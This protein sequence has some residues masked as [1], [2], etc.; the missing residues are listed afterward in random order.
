MGLQVEKCPIK[1]AEDGMSS[2]DVE[3]SK[4]T[5]SVLEKM[6]KDISFG[7]VLYENLTY[8][9]A[10]AKEKE[11]AALRGCHQQS[12]GP[13]TSTSDWAVYYVSGGTIK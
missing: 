8:D 9:R 13:R 12:G 11:E 7:K 1:E 10:L 3:R 2:R 6:S 4:R 5:D